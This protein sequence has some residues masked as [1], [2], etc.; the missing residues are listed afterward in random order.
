M[1][2]NKHDV[3]FGLAVLRNMKRGPTDGTDNSRVGGSI[4]QRI[5]AG[6]PSTAVLYVWF[7]DSYSSQDQDHERGAV[8]VKR[9]CMRNEETNER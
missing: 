6:Q 8:F 3:N 4:C 2:L 5:L 7:R 1:R 9:P